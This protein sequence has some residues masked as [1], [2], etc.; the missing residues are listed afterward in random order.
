MLAMDDE[1]R[2]S[3]SQ[4][5]DIPASLKTRLWKLFAVLD[6]NG[7]NTGRVALPQLARFFTNV[8]NGE[9]V[10]VNGLSTLV[11]GKSELGF[12]EFVGLCEWFGGASG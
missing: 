10:T 1:P 6:G 7:E 2:P 5:L 9:R 12:E 3:F 11:Q 4:N 8:G